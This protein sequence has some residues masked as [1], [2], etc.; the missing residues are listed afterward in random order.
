MTNSSTTSSR[1]A[2][3][4][5]LRRIALAEWAGV[6]QATVNRVT[7]TLVVVYDGEAQGF[8]TDGGRWQTV[9][10][11]HGLILSHDTLALAKAHAAEVEYWCGVCSGEYPDPAAHA[12]SW[13]GL[14]Y[15]HGLAGLPPES[16]EV[17]DFRRESVVAEYGRGYADGATERAA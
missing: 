4:R 1:K 3:N 17:P 14:G 8:D 7:G 12:T 15:N 5:R 10:E 9:C 11:D 13:W 16:P 2:Q 6:R